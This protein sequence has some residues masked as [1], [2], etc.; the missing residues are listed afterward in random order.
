[1]LQRLYQPV[2]IYIFGMLLHGANDLSVVWGYVQSTNPITLYLMCK[3]CGRYYDGLFTFAHSTPIQSGLWSNVNFNIVHSC[4]FFQS[5][6]SFFSRNSCCD[7]AET[8]SR[9]SRC[10]IIKQRILFV[11]SIIC[12]KTNCGFC[13]EYR[14]RPTNYLTQNRYK[15]KITVTNLIQY[16]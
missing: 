14:Q 2:V 12:I 8:F 16:L 4:G 1:M 13:M 15:K 5:S 11:R 7:G 9:P 3:K 10:I 6:S